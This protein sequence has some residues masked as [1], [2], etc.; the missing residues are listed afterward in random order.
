MIIVGAQPRSTSQPSLPSWRVSWSSWSSSTV[1]ACACAWSLRHPGPGQCCWKSP[2]LL[3]A[4]PAGGPLFCRPCSEWHSGGENAMPP[5]CKDHCPKSSGVGPARPRPACERSWK[6]LLTLVAVLYVHCPKPSWQ[7]STWAP[8]ATKARTA[9]MQRTWR[10]SSAAPLQCR[11]TPSSPSRRSCGARSGAR[12]RNSAGTSPWAVVPRGGS[13]NLS[14][15][16]KGPRT[17]IGV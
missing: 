6:H 16:E 2:G 9:A 12:S 1:A 11:S 15:T 17:L 8:Q 13:L 4:R 3:F 10:C 7:C 14:K 5:T